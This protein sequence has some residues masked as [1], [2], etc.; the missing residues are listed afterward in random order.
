MAVGHIILG[1][2]NMSQKPLSYHGI[3]VSTGWSGSWGAGTYV[4]LFSHAITIKTP[5]GRPV[6][7]NTIYSCY[8]NVDYVLTDATATLMRGATWIDGAI[9]STWNRQTIFYRGTHFQVGYQWWTPVLA[10]GAHTIVA[11]LYVDRNSAVMDGN[12]GGNSICWEQ[13]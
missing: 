1:G 3:N 10:Q 11:G 4:Q 6:Y 8:T 13:P 7:G 9:Y 5:G 12:D 2:T